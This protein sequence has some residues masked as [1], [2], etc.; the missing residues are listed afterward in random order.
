MFRKQKSLLDYSLL[1]H[2]V[3]TEW[4]YPLIFFFKYQNIENAEYNSKS[5]KLLSRYDDI[6]LI[7][8]FKMDNEESLDR[9]YYV[10]VGYYSVRIVPGCEVLCVCG[11][12]TIEDQAITPPLTMTSVLCAHLSHTVNQWLRSYCFLNI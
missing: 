1:S 3:I 8:V 9:K 12:N 4:Y 10:W 2:I 5:Y 7:I 6:L 11:T